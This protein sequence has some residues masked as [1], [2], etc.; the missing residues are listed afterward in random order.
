MFAMDKR[1]RDLNILSP[2]I[3]HSQSIKKFTPS[4]TSCTSSTSDL[5]SRSKLE[6]SKTLPVAAVSTP[7]VPRF[8]SLKFSRIFGNQLFWLS[9]G[10]FICTPARSPVPRLDG[11][12]KMYTKR[13][14][15]MNSQPFSCIHFSTSLRPL[16]NLSNT[17]FMMLPFSIEITHVWS[18]SFT[19]TRKLFSSLCQIP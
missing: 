1:Q 12:V 3:H 6:M 13:S 17:L 2:P 8:C 4:M 5:P 11:Q 9:S 19:Q 7:P 14:F 15:H 10:S 16:Q 18:S